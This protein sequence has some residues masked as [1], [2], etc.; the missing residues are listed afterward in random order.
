MR[1]STVV[2]NSASP[3]G[4]AKDASRA[5]GPGGGAA[6]NR[7]QAPGPLRTG[8]RRA[9]HPA[10][11]PAR[12]PGAPALLAV[13]PDGLIVP[14]HPSARPSGHGTADDSGPELPGHAPPAPVAARTPR[15]RRLADDGT[16][17][18]A[19]VPADAGINDVPAK[20]PVRPAAAAQGRPGRLAAAR[21]LMF[22]VLAAAMVLALGTVVSGQEAGTGPSATDINRELSWAQTAA[23]LAQARAARD[24]EPGPAAKALL[25]QSA[26]D[27]ETQLAGL[28]DSR[29]VA[30]SAAAVPT[31]AAATTANFTAA[32]AA[33]ANVLLGDSLTA[34]GAVGR[35]FASAGTNRL[36]LASAL[37]KLL[38]RPTPQSPYLSATGLPAP[39]APACRK[40][41]EPQPGASA[42][43]AL[44]AAVRAEQQAVY[45]YQVAGSRLA[46][47]AFGRAAELAGVHRNSLELLNGELARHCL[48]AVPA[49]PGFVLAP[50]FTGA[51]A[52]ALATL[53]G[54]LALVYAD[55]A[56]LSA[57][58]PVAS[59][60][61]SAPATGATQG[62]VPADRAL[63]LREIAVTGLV[64][65]ALRQQ[66]W[67]GAL[68]ALPGIPAAGLNVASVPASLSA[69]P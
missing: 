29:G 19:V 11:A 23:L 46:E 52:A 41:K 68:G 2:T 32:L 60:V 9:S 8:P 58:V 38:G 12:A 42:D 39:D 51:P 16:P 37:D 50:D 40:T 20:S 18:A 66:E 27:L 28:A 13:G 4:P 15:G 31:A 56:A 53:E 45:A 7:K 67:G 64:G 36:L 65:S 55:V 14:F 57:P 6:L 21:G 69:R 43:A 22:A 62:P 54:Q 61:P 35:T 17:E 44:T 1:P 10:G 48:P 33:S 5:Q 26:A 25:Q 3:A 24:A 47:P 34:E 63:T 30:A 59:G 49:V